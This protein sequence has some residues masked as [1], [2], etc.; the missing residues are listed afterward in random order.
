MKKMLVVT[1]LLISMMLLTIRVSAWNPKLNGDANHMGNGFVGMDDFAELNA[2]W[3]DGFVSGLEGYCPDTDIWSAAGGPLDGYVDL[4]DMAYVNANW[5]HTGTQV[6]NMDNLFWC[7]RNFPYKPADETMWCDWVFCPGQPSQWLW[8]DAYGIEHM[9]QS[10]LTAPVFIPS[11]IGT[12]YYMECYAPFPNF[13]YGTN[14]CEQGTDPGGNHG[15]IFTP[16]PVGSI[17]GGQHRINITFKVNS[18]DWG[19]MNGLTVTVWGKF[20]NGDWFQIVIF[21]YI[22]G[23]ETL[24]IPEYPTF[25][26]E[27]KS[28]GGHTWACATTRLDIFVPQNQWTTV[29][30]NMTEVY[31]MLR[32]GWGDDWE[33]HV[34]ALTYE[35]KM[36][37]AAGAFWVKKLTY[38]S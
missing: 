25:N 20:A 27:T 28:D 8:I 18:I 23:T 4:Y 2:H 37:N 36:K 3:W 13:I 16:I 5:H 21:V 1:L 17:T 19:A 7:Q 15:Y 12:H 31:L 33:G 26:F 24:W 9:E 29:E 10:N 38:N 14:I 32:G 22:V 34:T 35:S 30:V 11:G 6:R